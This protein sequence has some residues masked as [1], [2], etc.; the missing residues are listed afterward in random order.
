MC[1]PAN[2]EK[3]KR[4]TFDEIVAERAANYQQLVDDV[5]K[6]IAELDALDAKAAE[7]R[8]AERQRREKKYTTAQLE[9]RKAM[10]EDK[11]RNKRKY[12]EQV[13]EVKAESAEFKKRMLDAQTERQKVNPDPYKNAFEIDLYFSNPKHCYDFLLKIVGKVKCYYCGHDKCY[14]LKKRRMHTC[15]SCRR[16]FSILKDSIFEHIRFGLPKMFRLFVAENKSINGLTL[17]EVKRE[18]GVSFK[19]ALKHLHNIRHS[20]FSQINTIIE[21]G[22]IV[23]FD[24]TAV[25]GENRNRHDY[26]KLSQKQTYELA[27]QVAGMKQ[28]NGPAILN[29]IAGLKEPTVLNEFRSLPKCTV[30]TDGHKSTANLSQLGFIHESVNHSIGEHGRGRVNSNA[31]ESLFM[32][33]K[34]ALGAHQNCFKYL[35][36]ML[37]AIAHE[38]NCEVYKFTD[39]EK[40]VKSATTAM[41]VLKPVKKKIQKPGQFKLGMLRSTIVSIQPKTKLRGPVKYS[42]YRRDKANAVT[43]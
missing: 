21:A 25:I 42:I 3:Q 8:K 5:N 31:A 11:L 18:I 37:N 1:V 28:L 43:I 10:L 36:L 29:V 22:S 38:V 17:K 41:Q 24:T 30:Y 9:I 19:T 27:T 4:R 15:A 32:V 2:G 34:K 23:H 13:A 26:A 20:A 39:W 16:Q 14:G 40:I 12:A 6:L 7:K 33:V 35:Q